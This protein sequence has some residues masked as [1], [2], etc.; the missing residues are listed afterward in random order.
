MRAKSSAKIDVKHIA[1]LAKLPIPAS[2]YE[3][4]QKELSAII[5]LVD[6]LQEI[7]TKKVAPTNQVTGQE[8]VFREDIVQPSLSQTDA[9]VNAKKTHDGYFVVAA[10]L[11]Q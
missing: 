1:T 7:D 4:F 11:E 3:K 5:D 9:L 6:K 10:V 2:Q 8:N